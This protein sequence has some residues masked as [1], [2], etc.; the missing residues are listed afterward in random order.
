MCSFRDARM[1]MLLYSASYHASRILRDYFHE[2]NSKKNASLQKVTIS[3]AVTNLFF[4]L[5][6][7]P[8]LQ[9][10][11]IVFDGFILLQFSGTTPDLC[12]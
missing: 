11:Q 3:P 1:T 8:V 9:I 5:F 10:E 7:P 12:Q 2:N 4:F 6:I